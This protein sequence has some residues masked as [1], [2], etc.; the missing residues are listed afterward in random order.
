VT[1]V[2][3]VKAPIRKYDKLAAL[4]VF[5]QLAAEPSTLDDF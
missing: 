2:Q 5:R 1:H 4:L 3:R